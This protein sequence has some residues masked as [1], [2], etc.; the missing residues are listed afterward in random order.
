MKSSPNA[1]QR[2]IRDDYTDLKNALI[3][4]ASGLVAIDKNIHYFTKFLPPEE[5]KRVIQHLRNCEHQIQLGTGHLRE[6]LAIIEPHLLSETDL[7]AA[8]AMHNAECTAAREEKERGI[9]EEE[10]RQKKEEK[11]ARRKAYR[12]NR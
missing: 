8:Q 11:K 12:K 7:I 3:D 9:T 5:R 10:L 1:Q 2:A 4:I 6:T